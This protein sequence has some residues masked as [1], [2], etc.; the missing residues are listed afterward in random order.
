MQKTLKELVQSTEKRVYVH[1]SDKKTAK[2]FIAN[3]EKEGFKFSG[4]KSISE[5]P[6]DDFYALNKNLTVNYINF[7]G[8]IA[9]QCGADN[10][11]R[12]EYKDLL[13]DAKNCTSE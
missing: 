7:I 8:R 2:S 1:L 5:M 9:Y 13:A 12:L 3:A 11:L 4:G 6:P 10:I